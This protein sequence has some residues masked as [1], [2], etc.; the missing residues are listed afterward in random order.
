[1][2]A[3]ASITSTACGAVVELSGAPTNGS[4]GTAGAV[5]GSKAIFC[6]IEPAIS[7]RIADR[8]QA[9]MAAPSAPPKNRPKPDQSDVLQPINAP[10]AIAQ[11]IIVPRAPITQPG[12]PFRILW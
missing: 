7:L 1:M 3:G 11:K 12:S 10:A 9:P 8:S 5:G 2:A 4:I 6:L